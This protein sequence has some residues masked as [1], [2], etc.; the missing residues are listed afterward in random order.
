[1]FLLC[2]LSARL[3]ETQL[4]DGASLCLFSTIHL[5][6]FLDKQKEVG[7]FADRF[8]LS[9]QEKPVWLERIEEDL[10]DG[11]LDGEERATC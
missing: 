4:I 11:A 1:M 9:Q 6:F 10:S 5:L 2:L 7:S 3:L 8:R